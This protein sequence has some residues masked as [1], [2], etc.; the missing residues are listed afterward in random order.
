MSAKMKFV[1]VVAAA[2]AIAFVT[3]PMTS[4]LAHRLIGSLTI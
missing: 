3:A 1:N 4:S 2:A